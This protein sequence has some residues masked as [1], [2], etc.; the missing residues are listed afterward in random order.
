MRGV[1]T[2]AEVDTSV[3][4][5]GVREV[6]ENAAFL[7][8]KAIGWL[9]N[10]ESFRRG[11]VSLSSEKKTF[12]LCAKSN[13]TTLGALS[14]GIPSLLDANLIARPTTHGTVCLVTTLIPLLA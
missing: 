2:N 6:V 7:M 4:D 3:A 8:F 10:F 13:L 1:V 14:I 9:T 11:E 12:S 5:G